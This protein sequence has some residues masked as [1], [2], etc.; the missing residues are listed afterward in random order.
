MKT[1]WCPIGVAIILI[2]LNQMNVPTISQEPVLS[3]APAAATIHPAVTTTMPTLHTEE[4]RADDAFQVAAFPFYDGFESGTLVQ[5]WSAITSTQGRVRVSDAHGPYS[6]TYHVLLDDMVED[7][8]YSTATLLL[9][10][11][12]AGQPNVG[13]DFWWRSF[14]DENHPHDGV[15]ISDDDGVS[16]SQVFS[17]NDGPDEYERV[18]V[19]LDEQTAAAGLTLNDHFQLKFQFYDNNPIAGDGY[20]IDEVSVAPQIAAFPFYDGF[21]SGTLVQGW[22]VFTTTQGR[23]R[24]S[25]AHEPYSGTYHVLLDDV[26]ED[27]TYSTAT[28]I[29]TIDLVDQSDVNLDFWWR[30]FGDENHPQDGVFISDDDGASWSQVLSF[31]NGP[32]EYEQKVIALSAAASAAG[33][34][35]NDH[36]Q[37]KF[38]FYDNYAIPG[39]GYAI[40]Q[41]HIRGPHELYLPLITRCW[42]PIPYAPEL[43]AIE[44]TGGDGSYTVNW[45]IDN[46]A[47]NYTLEEST[48][49]A[50]S[51]T[52]D[53]YLGASISHTV[54][55]KGPGRYYYRVRACNGWGCSDW[56]NVEWVD[57]Q[58][59]REPNDSF[60]QANGPLISGLGYYGYPDDVNDRFKIH[61]HAAGQ[62]HAILNNHTGSGDVQLLLYNQSEEFVCRDFEW[63]YEIACSTPAGW[64]YIRIY[65]ESGHNSNTPYTLQATFP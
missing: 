56:S 41:V 3:I 31:N 37:I 27:S 22:S 53:I 7:S 45:S 28:L 13:L 65:T 47:D 1:I 30:G 29:L 25:N 54:V 50:F 39:D 23:V 10:I 21:E 42:P 9:T 49:N 51:D 35:F 32:D 26:V 19:D 64:Y 2:L 4:T 63:P 43:Y 6:G 55:D 62:V 38:Q 14:G 5:G 36:F 8:T 48:D 15:F 57:V 17:F 61:L 20:A 18:S 24:V 33:R 59:E 46:L 12:L 58:W 44:N 34:V 11:D 60:S 16:W 52:V 40:D